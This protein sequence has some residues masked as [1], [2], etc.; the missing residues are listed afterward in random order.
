MK[1]LSYCAGAKRPTYSTITEARDAAFAAA[2]RSGISS[3][4]TAA[5]LP[6]QNTLDI[7]FELERCAHDMVA[8]LT[9][10]ADSLRDSSAL[11]SSAM[12]GLPEFVLQRRAG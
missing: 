3:A 9:A 2:A 11:I 7:E 8:K 12:N 6:V 5:F 1:P 4:A 10:I